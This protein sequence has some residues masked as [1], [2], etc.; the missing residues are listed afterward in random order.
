MSIVVVGCEKA[1]RGALG[2]KKKD[3]SSL[4]HERGCESHVAWMPKILEAIAM[5]TQC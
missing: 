4:G 5:S 2:R 3:P 1:G